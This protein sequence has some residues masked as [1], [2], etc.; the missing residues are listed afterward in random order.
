LQN[1]VVEVLL[2]APETIATALT[3]RKMP[4]LDAD[5]LKVP[6][7]HLVERYREIIKASQFR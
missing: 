6:L 4:E 3:K 1:K 7:T 2:A 5:V